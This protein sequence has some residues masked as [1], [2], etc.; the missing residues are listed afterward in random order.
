MKKFMFA[1][2]M[3]LAIVGLCPSLTHAAP[4]PASYTYTPSQLPSFWKTGDF[5][6]PVSYKGYTLYF[7]ADPAFEGGLARSLMVV[8]GIEFIHPIKTDG[9]DTFYWITDAVEQADGSLLV[10]AIE[11]KNR[12]DMANDGWAFEIVDTDLFVVQDAL[13][14]AS[15]EQ[16]I[17]LESGWWDG[18]SGASVEFSDQYPGMAFVKDAWCTLFNGDCRTSI[19]QYDIND[20]ASSERVGY[21]PVSGMAFAPVQTENGWYGVS[22]DYLANTSTLWTTDAIGNEWTEVEVYEYD[23]DVD[24]QTHAHGLNV[25]DGQVIHRWSVI[26]NRPVQA[27][28]DI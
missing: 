27:V 24:G 4:A 8:N 15:W 23:M 1:T 28:L 2:L 14:P 21:G 17:K 12:F 25:V 13:N 5:G 7:Y 18:N 26:R 11:V 20:I 19:L 9:Q 16:A 3:V 6:T 10:A 22:W